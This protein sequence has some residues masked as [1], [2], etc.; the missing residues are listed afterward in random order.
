MVDISGV[1]KEFLLFMLWAKM[2]GHT[3]F[4]DGKA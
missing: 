1:E 2:P 4:D 3:D